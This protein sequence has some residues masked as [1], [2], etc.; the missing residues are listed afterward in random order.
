MKTWLDW[1]NCLFTFEHHS[2][3][4]IWLLPVVQSDHFLQYLTQDERRRANKFRVQTARD[5]YVIARAT[6]RLLLKKYFRLK[7]NEIQ[8]ALNPY[9]KPYLAGHKIFFN[10]SHS[11]QWVLIGLSNRTEIGVDIEKIRPDLNLTQ[12]AN[13][14]FSQKEVEL[15]HQ[16]SKDQ[17]AEGFFNAWTRKEA[18]I[19]AR[20]MGLAIPLSGFSVELRPGQPARLLETS[21]DPQAIK[22]WFLS[23]IPAPENYK[24]AMVANTPDFELKLWFGRHFLEQQK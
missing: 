11:Y 8:F 6:L 22:K 10:V 1:Q 14:F 21:H 17:I 9:G 15:L 24:A 12:L 2:Q 4:D 5:Q 18:Y 19:K 20:G 3:V 23:D 16:L 13:R 7:N